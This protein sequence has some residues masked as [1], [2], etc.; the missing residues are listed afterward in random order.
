M[1]TALRWILEEQSSLMVGCGFSP[2][3]H[4]SYVSKIWPSLVISHPGC[5]PTTLYTILRDGAF[6]GNRLR[7]SSLF[8]AACKSACLGGRCSCSFRLGR[9]RSIAASQR[10]FPQWVS[11][12]ATFIHSTKKCLKLNLLF[13]SRKTLPERFLFIL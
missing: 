13:K 1:V 5:H 6:W 12:C 9:N 3:V 7:T 11:D 10:H 4:N 2:A 8:Q